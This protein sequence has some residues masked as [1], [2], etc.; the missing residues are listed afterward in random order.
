MC[1]TYVL[2]FWSGLLLTIELH[3]H[4]WSWDKCGLGDLCYAKTQSIS[5]ELCFG[6]MA[7]AKVSWHADSGDFKLLKATWSLKIQCFKKSRVTWKH[8]T[9]Q[10]AARL[11]QTLIS[12]CTF[13]SSVRAQRRVN[14]LPAQVCNSPWAGLHLFAWIDWLMP[15]TGFEPHLRGKAQ[16]LLVPTTVTYYSVPESTSTQ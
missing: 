8:L 15:V 2:V 3:T 6:A 10:P 5:Y 13:T 16:G 7:T 1:K 14:S 9:H 11:S 12:R 4:H